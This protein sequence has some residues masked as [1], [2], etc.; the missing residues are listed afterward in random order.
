MKVIKVRDE[1][2]DKVRRL[3]TER[4]V[5]MSE[6]TEMVTSGNQRLPKNG[7]LELEQVTD[8]NCSYDD[9][10]K[11]VTATLWSIV[12]HTLNSILPDDASEDEVKK[13]EKR[14][15]GFLSELSEDEQR[16]AGFF[17]KILYIIFKLYAQDKK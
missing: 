2:Y 9:Q 10:S 11:Q 5:T 15:Q 8:G 7:N 6:A 4:G 17:R 3:A 12:E 1:F 14:W 13:V 16:L